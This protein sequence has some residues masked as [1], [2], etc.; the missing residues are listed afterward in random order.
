[1]AQDIL[2]FV[3][4]GA[5]LVALAIPLGAYMAR[6]FAGEAGFL[7]W[8]E[9]PIFAAAGIRPEQGDRKSVV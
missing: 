1:M 5:V 7:R 3:L 4:F 6:V 8:L 2:Q 9:R